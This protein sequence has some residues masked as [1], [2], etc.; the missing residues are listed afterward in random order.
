MRIYRVGFM[1]TPRKIF[2]KLEDNSPNEHVANFLKELF[3]QENQGLHQ[4]NAKY[5]EL[6]EKYHG[7]YLDED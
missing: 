2:K 6:I 7:G 3:I 1:S 5:D 4:W